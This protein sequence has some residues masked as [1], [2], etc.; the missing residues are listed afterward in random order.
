[1]LSSL[2]EE[3]GIVN[4]QQCERVGRVL[5][6]PCL[7][8][9]LPA[10][11]AGG[12]GRQQ[13][14][15]S[16]A[17][18][19]EALGKL[20][21]LRQDACNSSL[22]SVAT[23]DNSGFVEDA[24]SA[25]LSAAAVP[26]LGMWFDP[27]L[28]RVE[29]IFE[30]PAEELLENTSATDEDEDEAEK[31]EDEE[32]ADGTLR[33][34]RLKALMSGSTSRT[35]QLTLPSSSA[36]LEQC[37]LD[38]QLYIIVCVVN[39]EDKRTL[40]FIN[41]AGQ[42]TEIASPG[43]NNAIAATYAFL[44]ST[45]SNTSTSHSTTSFPSDFCG[46]EAASG[47][48]A[49]FGSAAV[50]EFVSDCAGTPFVCFHSL[51]ASGCKP[52]PLP[53][54]V[55]DWRF[56]GFTTGLRGLQ[57]GRGS[58]A[59]HR[60]THSSTSP[61]PPS[62]LPAANGSMMLFLEFDGVSILPYIIGSCH[63]TT[64]AV[65]APTCSPR[66]IPR[67]IEP[68]GGT[69]LGMYLDEGLSIADA[70]NVQSVW[71]DSRK[72]FVELTGSVL[73]VLSTN[74]LLAAR[75][76]DNSGLQPLLAT[77]LAANEED[78]DENR[79]LIIGPG[80]VCRTLFWHAIT[81][82]LMCVSRYGAGGLVQ[83]EFD[84]NDLPNGRAVPIVIPERG[85]PLTDTDTYRIVGCAGPSSFSVMCV[86]Q[87]IDGTLNPMVLTL[88]LLLKK[89]IHRREVFRLPRQEDGTLPRLTGMGYTG[90]P[91]RELTLID[92]SGRSYFVT[93]EDKKGGASAT[94]ELTYAGLTTTLLAGAQFP[95]LAVQD[96]FVVSSADANG[97]VGV[98]GDIW[99]L[100]T[101]P[102]L[103]GER[104]PTVQTIETFQPVPTTSPTQ[105]PT[106]PPTAVPTGVPTN[107]PTNAPTNAPTNSPTAPP[108]NSPTAPPTR[109]PT[110]A[111][112]AAPT[113]T[114]TAPSN[115][116]VAPTVGATTTVPPTVG[117]TTTAGVTTT[118]PGVATTTA[119]VVTTTTTPV[120]T[121]TTPLPT[122]TTP[123]PPTTVETRPGSSPTAPPT[124]VDSDDGQ[125]LNS[126]VTFFDVEGTD[127]V[128]RWVVVSAIE[129]A[130]PLAA[131][132]LTSALES[133][134]G[135][136]IQLPFAAAPEKYF[137]LGSTTPPPGLVPFSEWVQFYSR[138][139]SQNVLWSPHHEAP[140]CC[141]NP[142]VNA[143]TL[144]TAES[145]PDC[146]LSSEFGEVF[147]GQCKLSNMDPVPLSASVQLVVTTLNGTARAPSS[148][149]AAQPGRLT[150][151]PFARQSAAPE[152]TSEKAQS[153]F[154]QLAETLGGAHLVTLQSSASEFLCSVPPPPLTGSSTT[155]PPPINGTSNGTSSDTP[156]NG[157]FSETDDG[158]STA[159]PAIPVELTPS[160]ASSA[161]CSFAVECVDPVAGAGVRLRQGLQYIE[162][163]SSS[164]GSISLVLQ[165]DPVRATVFHS[166][167]ATLVQRTQDI[168][169]KE[170]L[171]NFAN[172]RPA[173]EVT[174]EAEVEAQVGLTLDDEA[175]DFSLC[176]PLSQRNQT[177]SAFA[178][179]PQR[180]P[181]SKNDT[182]RDKVSKGR[183]GEGRGVC[184]RSCL[185]RALLCP[186]LRCYR[187]HRV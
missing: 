70:Q 161:A 162:V 29:V 17:V 113:R 88:S 39:E 64:A 123:L 41:L 153:F 91:G 42:L 51:D 85:N 38:Y 169:T 97:G 5:N 54:N 99:L 21:L 83:L 55:S 25:S 114:P 163:V 92:I 8:S 79:L 27:I 3:S 4:L 118:T 58:W 37:F 46:H 186:L 181:L 56:L 154:V 75:A 167:L 108:T 81:E 180:P 73:R 137:R 94:G 136:P 2:A 187:R 30:V 59:D 107:S 165:P 74:G 12:Y 158:L 43:G 50:V 52:V 18:Y 172:Q 140:V 89:E 126:T 147:A 145:S 183:E 32:S 152:P 10:L 22:V 175:E 9:T 23:V 82:K 100:V 128:A 146:W 49:T 112:T 77:F 132:T 182:S 184:F 66:L 116:T 111:P 151:V 142:A 115:S 34:L 62:L 36:V 78:P 69:S 124:I 26:P 127:A 95:T 179:P 15:A 93:Y 11:H 60:N 84:D 133:E 44:D 110:N 106:L 101:T 173:G 135:Q 13:D 138:N 168:T 148:L 157:T 87:P 117:A 6:M 105:S 109:S 1:M 104:I 102:A 65:A 143:L 19:D 139:A 35:V 61:P 170:G 177:K 171:L 48:L 174:V 125:R 160:P 129:C 96:S 141:Q 14:T 131:D 45:L 24:G 155:A 67:E 103:P 185:Q 122:T 72:I 144:L 33:T 166:Q 121:T 63:F 47:P 149:V 150:L 176:L 119:A 7:R 71:I 156:T 28:R 130:Q 159:V 86:M 16:N 68:V 80:L 40:R 90:L 98:P 164:N 53:R 20:V 178:L 134:P 57:G 31:E 76:V 120:P